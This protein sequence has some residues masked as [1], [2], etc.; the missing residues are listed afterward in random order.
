MRKYTMVEAR[1][2]QICRERMGVYREVLIFLAATTLSLVTKMMIAV[3]GR[4]SS[5]GGNCSFI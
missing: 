2:R 1:K 5:Y 3:A 4:G